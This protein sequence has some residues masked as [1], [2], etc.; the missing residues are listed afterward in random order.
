MWCSNR[1]C[2]Y[3]DYGQCTD[4]STIKTNVCKFNFDD[5]RIEP[6]NDKE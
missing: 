5:K 2:K 3:W 6:Q 4:S 1:L